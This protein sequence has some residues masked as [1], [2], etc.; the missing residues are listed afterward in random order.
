MLTG[1]KFKIKPLKNLFT[2]KIYNKE[3]QNLHTKNYKI[4]S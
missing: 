2:V 4:L 3:N 1:N